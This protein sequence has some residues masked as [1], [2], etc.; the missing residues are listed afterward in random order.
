MSSIFNIE[1]KTILVHR[2]QF[3]VRFITITL[4]MF[5]MVS[6][7]LALGLGE[8]RV[9]SS[10]GQ[11]LV[12][13]VDAFGADFTNVSPTCLRA[14]VVNMD[15]GFIASAN[16][17][18]S[19]SAGKTSLVFSTKQA[20]NEPAVLL[21]VDINCDTQ[22]HR[23]FSILLDPPLSASVGAAP[24]RVESTSSEVDI[25]PPVTRAKQQNNIASNIASLEKEARRANNRIVKLAKKSTTKSLEDRPLLNELIP[26]K[27][28]KALPK[29][30]R[31][32]L[33]L[34]DETFVPPVEHG[35]KMSDILSSSAGPELLQNMKELRLAQARMAAALR[36]EQPQQ[37][38]IATNGV[39][40]TAF[41]NLQKEAAQ[42]KA[43]GLKDKAVIE[44]LKKKDDGSYWQIGLVLL[45]LLAVI[46]I[47]L[48]FYIRRHRH[49]PH[50]SWWESSREEHKLSA[51]EESETRIED[52]VDSVQVPYDS[53]PINMASQGLKQDSLGNIG[54]QNSNSA[55]QKF[56]NPETLNTG[57]PTLEETNSSIFNFF[58]PRA[59][60]VKVEEISDVTQE[61]EFWISMNDPQR[62][63][64]ILDAQEKVE[65]PDSPMPWLFLLDLYRTVKDKVKYD[66][67]R[68]RFIIF[69][70]A[71]IPEFETIIDENTARHLEDFPHLIECIC[72]SWNKNSAIP[73]LESLLVDDREGKRSGFD[74]PIY[75]DILMLL[76]I[77]HELERI[78][79]VDGSGKGWA[80]AADI[81][82]LP[83]D[84]DDSAKNANVGAIEFG[85]IDFPQLTRKNNS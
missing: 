69:F 27:K 65:H 54:A 40:L 31:D 33:K 2:R 32:V 68:D 7:V 59:S 39:D 4:L 42:L 20:I 22:L 73:Y 77:A 71:N 28:T 45:A 21:V 12:A 49:S 78:K 35:L 23:E 19:Q 46:V 29:V 47:F 52:I 64:E 6:V 10:L 50:S 41:E 9:R 84:E 57:A 48:L 83:L 70:N 14:R 43:Q 37:S 11:S 1:G 61:A 62:A 17:A 5:G 38:A 3:F 63:I 13:H 66:N 80:G 18:I 26:L 16:L 81:P 72:S 36:D 85:A 8:V 58:S 24:I 79:S 76:S 15:R 34:S 55:Q 56:N 53:K 74:L 67:L 44:E 82:K 60:S 51:I 30:N 25:T 75:R